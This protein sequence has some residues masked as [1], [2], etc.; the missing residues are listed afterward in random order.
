MTSEERVNAIINELELSRGWYLGPTWQRKFAAAI[1]EAVAE[2]RASMVP[3]LRECR[4]AVDVLSEYAIKA[5]VL[6]VT[7]TRQGLY[8][9]IDAI[10]GNVPEEPTNAE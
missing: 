5:G 8:G 6:G 3:L 10:I 9:R 1:A 4:A 7:K 2:E